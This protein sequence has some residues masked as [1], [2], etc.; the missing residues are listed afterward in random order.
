VS[1][2]EQA[3]VPTARAADA[4][5]DDPFTGMRERAPDFLLGTSAAEQTVVLGALATVHAPW[6]YSHAD[7]V[8]RRSICDVR[9]WS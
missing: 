9:Y 3:A 2:A 5:L 7:I 1:S 4:H 8:R 6:T